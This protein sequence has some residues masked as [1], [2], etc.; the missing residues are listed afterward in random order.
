MLA[1]GVVLA[2]DCVNANKIS[3]KMNGVHA[4]QSN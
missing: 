1:L 2:I 4:A 3:A